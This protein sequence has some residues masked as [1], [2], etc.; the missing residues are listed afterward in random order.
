MTTYCKQNIPVIPL[1]TGAHSDVIH[2][3][4]KVGNNEEY[5]IIMSTIQYVFAR[6]Q[7]V[8]CVFFLSAK[9]IQESTIEK[10]HVKTIA[11][12]TASSEPNVL[13]IQIYDRISRNTGST[14]LMVRALVVWKSFIALVSC[15][16]KNC[17]NIS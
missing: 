14:A 4:R 5:S 11:L 6:K 3:F 7:E 13:M 1:A 10:K 2:V 17:N 8:T 9:R 15:T 16:R 12:P